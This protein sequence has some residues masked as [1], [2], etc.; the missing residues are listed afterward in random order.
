MK[1]RAVMTQKF[2]HYTEDVLNE[3][4]SIEL[5]MLYE[6]DR[7]CNKYDIPYFLIYGSLIGAVRHQGFIPWDDDIDI[8]M[9]REDFE[10]LSK[11]PEAEWQNDVLFVKASDDVQF[12]RPICP[13]LYKRGTVFETE[14]H[15]QR[16]YPRK[17]SQY[18]SNPVWLD[19]FI[20]D[21]V[22]SYE[23]AI[24]KMNKMFRLGRL[25]FYAKYGVRVVKTEGVTFMVRCIIKNMMHKI[26]NITKH[27]EFKI[28]ER[29]RKLAF[30]DQGDY[31]ISF[32]SD[33]KDEIK[34]SFF[35][36][37]ETF[38]L[39]RLQFGEIMASVP[40]NYD[41]LLTRLYGDYMKLPP[42]NQRT[43]H[44]PMILDLGD[45]RGNLITVTE[46]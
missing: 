5:G 45:G 34:A 26:M 18:T 11:V 12:H 38:P 6:L 17:G 22:N 41:A 42:E 28:Y 13:R 30:K 39:S 25:Y 1:G 4:Q 24:K 44:P 7:V 14:R 3:L 40:R 29:Y 19:I 33:F 46:E 37:D 10:K 31:I 35:R 8:G 15:N 23:T 43:N 16:Y 9:M 27:P 2:Y 20:Y 36:Y 32:E 21:R